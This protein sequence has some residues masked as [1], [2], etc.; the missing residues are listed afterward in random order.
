MSAVRVS[1]GWTFRY[2]W[3]AVKG[4]PA[5]ALAADRSPRVCHGSGQGSG[6]K[7]GLCKTCNSLRPFSLA[8]DFTYETQDLPPDGRAADKSPA[9]QKESIMANDP[10]VPVNGSPSSPSTPVPS[11]PTFDSAAAIAQLHQLIAL[12]PGFEPPDPKLW[13]KIGRKGAFPNEYVQ[14]AANIVDASPGISVATNIDASVL[15][16]GVSLSDG[17]QALINEALNFADGLRFTDAKLRASLVD[18]SDQVYSLAPGVAR[19]NKSLTPHIDAMKHASRRRGGKKKAVTP[20][21]TAGAAPPASQPVS[22]VV[23]TA[24]VTASQAKTG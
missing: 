6:W 5:S 2:W 13:Q 12:V 7:Y 9:A 11:T 1:R 4:H 18:A 20:P 19:T 14:S 17:I 16:N 24:P 3:S 15:R 21:A 22:P 8:G 23:T 10:S